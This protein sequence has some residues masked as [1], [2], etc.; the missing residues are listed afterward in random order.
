MERRQEWMIEKGLAAGITPSRVE[1]TL[2]V[3]D[4]IHKDLG[5]SEILEKADYVVRNDR[6]LD[7]LENKASQISG[8][9]IGRL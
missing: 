5:I 9:I 4:R 6:T 2:G 8:E 1:M 7:S 3:K